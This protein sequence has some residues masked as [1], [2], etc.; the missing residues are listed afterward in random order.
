MPLRVGSFL[1]AV[2]IFSQG[3]LSPKTHK[4]SQLNH[5]NTIKYFLLFFSHKQTIKHFQHKL[6]TLQTHI[7]YSVYLYIYGVYFIHFMHKTLHIMYSYALY[8]L[9]TLHIS[10]NSVRKIGLQR[11]LIYSPHLYLYSTSPS[12]HFL[13]GGL[14]RIGGLLNTLTSNWSFRHKKEHT[15]SDVFFTLWHITLLNV[16]FITFLAQIIQTINE[17]IQHF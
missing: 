13:M 11:T 10:P 6:F 7:V 15:I 14:F 3:L 12:P 1:C 9:Y 17:V 4:Q 16:P 5:T 2:R 8:T